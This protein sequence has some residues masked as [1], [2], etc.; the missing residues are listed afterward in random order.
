MIPACILAIENDSD[1]EYM[2]WLFVRYEK[3]MYSTIYKILG[4]PW[5]TEDALQSCVE[6]LIDKIGTLKK[7]DEKQLANYIVVA[8]RNTA[9]NVLRYNSRHEE[10]SFDELNGQGN[11]D[12]VYQIEEIIIHKDNLSVLA[13]VWERLDEKNRYLLEAKYILEKS[14]E[15]ISIDLNVK[16]GSVRMALTRAKRKAAKLMKEESIHNE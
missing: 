1:R 10:W 15:E 3:L 14:D 11:N 13:K 4:K 9:Y 2:T 7:F 5:S 16:V 8:C 12:E 6:R